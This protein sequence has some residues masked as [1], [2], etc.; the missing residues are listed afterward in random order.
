MKFISGDFRPS[1]KYNFEGI[2]GVPLFHT[3]L[4][5]KFWCLVIGSSG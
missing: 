4:S 2:E 5:Y 1:L 3:F